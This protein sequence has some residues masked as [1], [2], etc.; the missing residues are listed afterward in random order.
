MDKASQRTAVERLAAEAPVIAPETP[1]PRRGRYQPFPVDVLPEPIRGF[2]TAGAAA[3]RCDVSMIALPLL[4]ALGAAIGGTRRLVLSADWAVAA[5]LWVAVVGDSG[6]GK[7]PAFKLAVGPLRRRQGEAIKRYLDELEEYRV[8]KLEYERDLKK[9]T[10]SKGVGPPPARP[11][12][13]Q[14]VRCV[15]SDTTVEALA[16][17]LKENPRGLLMARD[18][19]SGWIGSFDKYS[20]TKGSDASHWLSMH[21]GDSL[22]VDRRTGD[23]PIIY[24]P[25]AFVSVCGG[26]QP[27]VL[28]RALGTQHRENGLAARFLLAMPPVKPK[29]W[30]EAEI[31]DSH[32]REVEAIFDGL[33]RLRPAAQY[34]DEIE[35]QRIPLT[36]EAKAKWISYYNA[37]ND[38][39]T[40]LT[41][42]ERAAWS[43]LE[44][45]AARLALIVHSVR[46]VAGD[47]ATDSEGRVDGRSIQA[48]VALVD[49]F[50]NE[51]RRVYA[52]FGET[53][54]DRDDRR[55]IE[56]VQRH[57]GRITANDLRRYDRRVPSSDEANHILN[58][59][60]AAGEGRWE[61]STP[62]KSGP[63]TRWFVLTEPE[64]EPDADEAPQDV[65]VS[66]SLAEPVENE[67]LGDG[68]DE[69]GEV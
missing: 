56:L 44:E 14:A 39:A 48:G 23:P 9:W 20:P 27:G 26:V 49:W 25:Q 2:L 16:P 51:Q 52:L 65:S 43:K 1:E 34:D 21:N 7:T 31:D 4:A 37:H 10:T 67:R 41:G 61:N 29:Q 22:I 62:G 8:A 55:T 28:V 17:I 13:P 64:A 60:V 45:Y 32:K 24:V 68:D 69:W 35:P 15:V 38:E 66:E 63:P 54:G 59:L 30:T 3:L 6:V 42:D 11:E 53:A 18:E 58:R 33:L 19:L 5:I 46:E 57:G 47:L 40:R 36:Q 12:K 50:K